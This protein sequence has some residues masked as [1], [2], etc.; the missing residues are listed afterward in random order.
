M[1]SGLGRVV[2]AGRSGRSIRYHIGCGS[3]LSFPRTCRPLGFGWVVGA[4][5]DESWTGRSIIRGFSG[6]ADW[7]CCCA[8]G[9]GFEGGGASD[10][11]SLESDSVTYSS[12]SEEASGKVPVNPKDLSCACNSFCN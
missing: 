6:S 1:I 12:S 10:S 7:S 5:D 2:G 3:S 4:K 11:S 9:T 8:F